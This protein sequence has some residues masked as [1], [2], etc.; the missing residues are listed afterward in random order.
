MPDNLPNIVFD[1]KLHFKAEEVKASVYFYEKAWKIPYLESADKCDDS[2]CYL[3]DDQRTWGLPDAKEINLNNCEKID[4]ERF[5]KNFIHRIPLTMG[6]LPGCD[7]MKIIDCPLSK[8]MGGWRRF[9][10]CQ[11]MI[12]K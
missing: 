11:K 5:C 10:K 1:K 3:S 4:L 9:S 12:G 8:A 6:F 2:D 7:G